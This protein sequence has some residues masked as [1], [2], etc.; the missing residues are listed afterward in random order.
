MAL[1]AATAQARPSSSDGVTPPTYTVDVGSNPIAVAV[2]QRNLTAYVVNDGSVS[3]I[4]LRT[5]ANV[6]E[7][8]TGGGEGQNAIALVQNDAQAYITNLD[9]DTL[10]VLDT[11]TRTIVKTIRV[12]SGAIDVANA[13]VPGPNIA[14]VA[15]KNR[16]SLT[17]INTATGA[18]VQNVVL[19][20]PA[21]TL[22]DAPQ[23]PDVWA[24]SLDS[25]RIFVVDATRGTVT[26]TIDVDQVGPVSAI[27]FDLSSK[28]VWVAGIAG[29][30]VTDF[31]GNVLKFVPGQSLF[32][33]GFNIIDLELT[34]SGN[35]A[36]VE[37]SPFVDNPPK[38]QIAI[39]DTRTYAV[40]GHVT[41][42]RVPQ[43]FDIDT[44]RD[45]AYVPNYADDTVT[46]FAVPN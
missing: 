22:A 42:G 18:I 34:G 1:G 27:A 41:T 2:S 37:S 40:V 25:G 14:Y 23:G 5:H 29:V 8:N 6:A 38:G 39:V 45:V 36:L 30:A 9:K 13:V 16:K 10:A 15:F 24:G 11:T 3:E 33:S 44:V 35:Y 31:D 20:E 19:P 17:G 21:Q 46:Y 7:Y 4:S 26:R 32:S 43:T 28:R 12:G